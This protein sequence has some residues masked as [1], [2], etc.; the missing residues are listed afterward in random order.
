MTAPVLANAAHVRQFPAPAETLRAI[1]AVPAG[2]WIATDADNTMWAGDVGDELV[3]FAAS[4]PDWWSADVVRL[5]WYLNEM[6]HGDYVG[7]CCHAAKVWAALPDGLQAAAR[8]ELAVWLAGC[9]R[10]RHWLLQAL[11]TAEGRG[12]EVV[13]ISA[14]PRAAVE[15]AAGRMAVGHWPVLALDADRDGASATLREPVSVGDGKVLAWQASGRTPPALALGDSRWDLPLLHSAGVG[16]LVARA[17]DD[18]WLASTA[19]ALLETA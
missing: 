14:S 5:S 11:L 13:V 16:H 18:P 12:V 7:A 8:A 3:R 2:R 9:V 4:K 6:E 19:D 10:P 1:A 17:V 15:V